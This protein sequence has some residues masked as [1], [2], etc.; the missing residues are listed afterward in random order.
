METINTNMEHSENQGKDLAREMLANINNA[1]EREYWLSKEQ[2]DAE[3]KFNDSVVKISGSTNRGVEKALTDKYNIFER[4]L[5]HKEFDWGAER[6][7]KP[8]AEYNQVAVDNAQEKSF[9]NLMKWDGNLAD[10][11][12]SIMPAANDATYEQK[13]V[14]NS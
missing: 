12:K 8:E 9:E 13:Q 4:N 5:W 3:K 14:V 10:Q 2:A 1:A 11:L 7:I 6:N